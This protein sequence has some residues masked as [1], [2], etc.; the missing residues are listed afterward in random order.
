MANLFF[1]HSLGWHDPNDIDLMFCKPKQTIPTCSRSDYASLF[2][3]IAPETLFHQQLC[4]VFFGRFG[5]GWIH[6][7]LVARAVTSRPRTRKG[8]ALA[9]HKSKIVLIRLWMP[10]IVPDLQLQNRRMTG[11]RKIAR[12]P[13][14]A[15]L[16]FDIILHRV[17]QEVLELLRDRE[18]D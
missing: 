6:Q 2:T 18:E 12:K 1:R 15:H 13:T 8:C 14:E 5:F 7:W 16:V 9:C 10:E 3:S 17:L 11:G 4:N